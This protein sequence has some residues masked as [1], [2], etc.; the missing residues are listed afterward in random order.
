MLQQLLIH[1]GVLL[2]IKAKINLSFF[3]LLLGILLQQWIKYQI[4]WVWEMIVKD[5]EQWR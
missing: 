4:Q 3:E 2:Q 5:Q 1:G